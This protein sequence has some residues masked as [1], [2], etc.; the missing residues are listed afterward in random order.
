MISLNKRL[1]SGVGITS[2]TL[3]G[4][5]GLVYL[6][7][8]PYPMIRRP[9]A[10]IAPILLLPSYMS[11]D[12]NYRQAI[13]HV[14][15]AEQLVK[16]AS[17]FADITLG[18]EKVK[19]AQV[20]LNALPVW[21]LG[22]EPTRYCEMSECSWQFT[23]D[24]FEA[25]RAKIGRMEAMIFQEKNAINQYQQA[26]ANLQQAK[27]QYQA[28]SSPQQRQTVLSLWQTSLDQL[29]QLPPSTFAANLAST[30]LI[31]YKRDFEQIAGTIAGFQQT[32]T[33]I[34]VAQQFAVAATKSCQNPPHQVAQ[35]EQCQKLWQQALDRL[36]MVAPTEAGYLDAQSLLAQYQ[37]NLG[38]VQVRL[39]AQSQSV[40]AIDNAKAQI[41]QIQASFAAGVE[42]DQRNSFISELQGTIDQLKKVQAGTTVYAEAQELLKSAQA[43]LKQASS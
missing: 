3:V 29:Q 7:N 10:G 40:E 31:A 43:K 16:N 15:Q 20:N 17:S 33:M 25:A 42:P 5:T 28:A 27:Q 13:A 24:E 23:F 18:E 39:K 30:K 21:F 11:M 22:Y 1:I 35:W 37:T 12:R 36:E 38:I 19:I 26:E 34:K 8:L 41:Q 2:A 4:L 6:V 32:N 9:V 14:E